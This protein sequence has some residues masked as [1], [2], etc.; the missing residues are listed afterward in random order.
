MYIYFYTRRQQPAFEYYLESPAACRWIAAAG[1]PEP[2][3]GPEST[4]GP[5]PDRR[6]GSGEGDKTGHWPC[7]PTAAGGNQLR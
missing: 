6:P 3:S 7:D 5:E 2:D 1:G 4:A